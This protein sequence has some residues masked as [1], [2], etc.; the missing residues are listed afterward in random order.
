MDSLHTADGS[1]KK[2]KRGS[3]VHKFIQG[4]GGINICSKTFAKGSVLKNINN[5]DELSISDLIDCNT[6]I[7]ISKSDLFKDTNSEQQVWMSHGDSLTKIP[8]GFKILAKT[9]NKMQHTLKWIK[10]H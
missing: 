2:I 9:K 8:K 1:T 6:I 3:L 10:N 7:K 5:I 4:D